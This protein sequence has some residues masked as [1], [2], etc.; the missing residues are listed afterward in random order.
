MDPTTQSALSDVRSLPDFGA[1]TPD[2]IEISMK[3]L[4][5]GV[6]D[7]LDAFEKSVTPTWEGTLGRLFK[8]TEPI[9]YA[10]R[11]VNLLKAT[12]DSPEVREAHAAIQPEMVALGARISQSRPLY[13][14]L[15][16]LK[17]SSWDVLPGVHQRLVEARIR[18]AELGGVGLEGE[19]LVRFKEIQTELAALG[20]KFSNNVLDSTKEFGLLVSDSSQVAGIAPPILAL[21]A[22][23][24]ADDEGRTEFDPSS[25]PWKVSLEQAVIGGILRNADDRDLRERVYRA[26]FTRAS[27][28]EFNNKGVIDQILRL[29]KEQ[30]ALLGYPNFAEMNF[31]RKMAD[32]PDA[33]WSF[34]SELR[35]A[36]KEG[37]RAHVEKVGQFAKQ[38]LRDDTF[39]LKIWDQ[40]F[41][42]EKLRE[43]L[44]GFNSEQLRRYFPYEQ[45]LDGL[46]EFCKKMF[47][48]SFEAA[49]GE[50]DVWDPDVRLF[51]V[52]ESDG[53]HIAYLYLDAFARPGEKVAGAWA[54]HFTARHRHEDGELQ[55]PSAWLVC[56]QMPPVEDTPS[57]MSFLEVTILF[58]EVGHALHNM[59]T[60]VEFAWGAGNSGIEWDAVEIPSTFMENW[61]YDKETLLAFARDYESG[62]PMPDELFD[63]ISGS[64]T[65]GSGYAMAN[66]IWHTDI[67]LELHH[68]FDPDSTNTIDD[69][70]KLVTERDLVLT[71]PDDDQFLCGFSHIFNGG[72]AAGYYT[73]LWSKMLS[74]DVYYAFVEAGRE[75]AY[76]VGKRFKD[77][78]FALGASRHPSEIFREFRGRDPQSGPMLEHL[79]LAKS[80]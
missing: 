67:D 9:N 4:L 27:S 22:K 3:S 51:R 79:G 57:L 55:L 59:L 54:N 1:I 53:E 60:K 76:E 56:N 63:K 24:A 14:A 58:H 41:W 44:Y 33:I 12:K 73:Y 45:V 64:R 78:I 26:Y 34:L 68:R 2:E 39:E 13:D 62:E 43:S 50:G 65:F 29:R 71:P 32:S 69:V 28:G 16:G 46:F 74:T 19:D 40:L 72:Y 52:R 48:V 70:V 42:G 37:N 31:V 20:T 80:K 10:W 18:E 30:A 5:A 35:D 8:I 77:T 17:E 47:G 66:M 6:G 61:C 49:D 36:S 75:N 23:N 15:I 21:M 11:I 38:T 7:Q 25:G